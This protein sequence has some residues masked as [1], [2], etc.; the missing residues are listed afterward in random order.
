ML[1]TLGAERREDNVCPL[2]LQLC[3]ADPEIDHGFL[4]DEQG[5]TN[6]LASSFFDV[7]LGHDETVEGYIDRIRYQHQAVGLSSDIRHPH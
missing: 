1:I 3:M 6:I 7:Q 4:F 2:S 5:R